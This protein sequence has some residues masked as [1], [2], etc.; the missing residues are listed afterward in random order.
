MWGDF[1]ELLCRATGCPGLVYD[2]L[3]YGKSSSTE[4]NRTI[5]YLHHS[6]LDE[7]PK[8][9]ERILQGTRYILV[10]H[11]DGGTIALIHGAERP[12]GLQGLVVEAAHVYVE[13]Q[14]IEGIKSAEQAWNEGKLQGL[15][16]F[17]GEK[18]EHVFRA[19]SN[20]WL[21]KWFRH[22]NIEY[23]LPSIE[24]PLLVIQG[25]N[26]HYGSSQHAM[27]ISSKSAGPA[28]LEIIDNCDHIPHIEAQPEVLKLMTEFIV[29][30]IR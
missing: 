28:Q 3:G 22:W 10:G 17:H 9:L 7:L 4:A 18:T 27:T 26:D 30:L 20:T 29:N 24:A 21:S 16:K 23:L 15:A 1:P 25:R 12:S 6:A 14:T 8:V 19:W 5:N 2:R 13:P 11:S